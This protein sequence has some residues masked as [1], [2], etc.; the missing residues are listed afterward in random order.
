LKGCIQLKAFFI[1]L[2]N[3]ISKKNNCYVLKDENSLC[4]L[5]VRT[6]A[7]VGFDPVFFCFITRQNV[8]V[9]VDSMFSERVTLA[10]NGSK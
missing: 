3:R 2:K 10:R 8:I 4:L 9:T 5:L 6:C 7:S 1:F